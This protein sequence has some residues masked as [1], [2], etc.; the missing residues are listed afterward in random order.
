VPETADQVTAE[1]KLPL[2]VTVT[3]HWLVFPGCTLAGTQETLTEVIDEDCVVEVKVPPV[4]PARN[5]APKKRRLSTALRPI[6]LLPFRKPVRPLETADY[7]L[8]STVASMPI[9][10]FQG[11]FM[12]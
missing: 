2:P 11:I 5:N 3:E 9:W 12:N 4:H 7:F 10:P 8:Q 6:I 1:L